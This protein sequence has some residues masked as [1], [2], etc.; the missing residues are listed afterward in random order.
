MTMHSRC[1]FP[2]TFSGFKFNGCLFSFTPSET[3]PVC[4]TLRQSN[5]YRSEPGIYRKVD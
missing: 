3:D 2:F 1:K 5:L 4:D